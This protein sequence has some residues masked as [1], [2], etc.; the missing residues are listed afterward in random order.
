[1]KVLKGKRLVVSALVIALCLVPLMAGTAN[2]WEPKKPITVVIPY[3]R[4]G[5]DVIGR[6]IQSVVG[7]YGFSK[8]P[9]IV[10]N[11]DG[12]SGTV[13]MQYLRTK[14]G[15]P[16]Y[17]M[18]S[19]SSIVTTPL[20]TN[21]GFT[22]RDLTP[23]CR[24]ALDRHALCISTK[25]YPDIYTLDQFVKLAKEAEAKGSPLQ[26]GG[27]GVKQEDQIVSI[28]LEK[29]T[30]IKLKYIPMKSGMTVAKNLIGGHIDCSVNNPSEFIGYTTAGEERQIVAFDKK[31]VIGYINVP[32]MPELG[33]PDATYQMLRGLFMAPGVKPEHIEYM[34][35]MIKKV[36]ATP[37]WQGFLNKIMLDGSEP[38]FGEEF[39]KWMEEYDAL[40]VKY[41]KEGGLI[42]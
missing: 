7:K 25:K 34:T 41:L 30:G 35:D 39:G 8:Q 15:D 40:H 42:H 38:I 29:A 21:V 32:T 28:M 27:T 20:H 19:L 5:A 23:F 10:I 2:A 17:F 31:R 4:G 36:I 24:L 9:L 26:V 11:K 12:G 3:A 22:W 14:K 1:M 16:H 18:V 6:F 13:G 33:Y 37:E